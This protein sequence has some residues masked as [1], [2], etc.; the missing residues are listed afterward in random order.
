V[1]EG[2]EVAEAFFTSAGIFL[3]AFWS[4][5]PAYCPSN[6]TNFCDTPKLGYSRKILKTS[7][8]MEEE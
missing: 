8:D 7:E 6:R 5:P 3:I 4:L 2:V 1:E